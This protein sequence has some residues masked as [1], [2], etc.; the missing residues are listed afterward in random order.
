MLQSRTKVQLQRRS[1]CTVF[2][3]FWFWDYLADLG[4]CGKVHK[5]FRR[6]YGSHISSKQ[7]C[8]CDSCFA[9]QQEG[10]KST[11]S[12]MSGWLEVHWAWQTWKHGTELVGCMSCYGHLR[13]ANLNDFKNFLKCVLRHFLLL[14][15]QRAQPL[16]MPIIF[17]FVDEFF[18]FKLEH[19]TFMFLPFISASVL[20]C[21]LACV[22]SC[23]NM[24]VQIQANAY[25]HTGTQTRR[26]T[27]MAPRLARCTRSSSVL[28][29]RPCTLCILCTLC[30]LC[31]LSTLSTLWPF[32]RLLC[33]LYIICTL[34]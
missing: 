31:T 7:C 16:L 28:V 6:K 11:K 3:N 14:L 10:E 32:D 27:R 12:W 21:V 2:W 26:R 17:A 24:N 23:R 15:R 8:P 30:T 29:H 25:R 5:N 19:I 34:C 18:H 22:C 33:T 4:F 9:Q 1:G 13:H 20:A